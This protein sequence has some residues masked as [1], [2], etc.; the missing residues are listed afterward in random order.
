MKQFYDTYSE[1]LKLSAV[2]TEI[3]WSNHLHILSKTKTIEEKLFYLNLCSK[4]YYSE[5]SL[6]KLI[7]NSTYERTAL[8]DKKLSAVVTEFPASAESIFKD[9]YVF[10]FLDLPD[11]YKEKD[12]RQAL[13]SHLKDFLFEMGPEFSLVGEEYVVQVG[14]KDFRIDL[15]LFHRGLNSLVAIELKTTEFKLADL[16]QLQFYLEALDQ[17][18][19]KEHENPS[20]GILICKTKDDEVVKYALNRNASPAKIAEYETRLIDK[21][22]LQR[23]LQE[24]SQRLTQED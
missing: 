2:L 20:I 23:K 11:L 18:I 4:N 12:L 5:R 10:D 14:K 6:R 3:T 8:S 24:V 21:E 22:I 9:T 1:D 19:K 15:L 7:D 13:I 16:G 17:D